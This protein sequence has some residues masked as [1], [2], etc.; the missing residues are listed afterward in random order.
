LFSRGFDLLAELQ[1]VFGHL[2][3]ITSHAD[4]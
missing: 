2:F 1:N 4:Y 3:L